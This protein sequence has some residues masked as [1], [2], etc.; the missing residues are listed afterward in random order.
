MVSSQTRLGML[1]T[2]PLIQ[3]FQKWLFLLSLVWIWKKETQK[4]QFVT[5]EHQVYTDVRPP[6]LHSGINLN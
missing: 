1:G 2:L 6:F 5:E 3:V 4:V